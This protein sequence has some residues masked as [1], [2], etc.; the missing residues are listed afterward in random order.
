MPEPSFIAKTGLVL[1][2]IILV[3]VAIY[4]TRFYFYMYEAPKIAKA[5]Y[6]QCL[7]DQYA[8]R[9]KRNKT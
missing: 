1:A 7:M 2:I 8:A 5:A 6:V 4:G 9:P 3:A